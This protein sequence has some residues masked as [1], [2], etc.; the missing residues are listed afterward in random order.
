MDSRKLA[1]IIEGLLFAAGDKVSIE[2]L[3]SI[4]EW[5]K[6]NKGCYK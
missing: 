4:I 1:G 5:T 2:K 6:N 3:S